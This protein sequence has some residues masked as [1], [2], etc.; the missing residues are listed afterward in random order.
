MYVYAYRYIFSYFIYIYIKYILQQNVCY[1]QNNIVLT[2]DSM[3][4]ERDYTFILIIYGKNIIFSN[5]TFLKQKFTWILTPKK[6]NNTSNQCNKAKSHI[7]QHDQKIYLIFALLFYSNIEKSAPHLK[8]K[9][10]FDDKIT[11]YLDLQNIDELQK[12]LLWKI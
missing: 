2:Q 12:I 5:I 6:Q 11:I 9:W 3:I 10:K 7:W 8:K 4:H 1:I